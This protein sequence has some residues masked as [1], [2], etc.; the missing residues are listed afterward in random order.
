MIENFGLSQQALVNMVRRRMLG[1]KLPFLNPVLGLHYRGGRLIGV[2]NTINDITNQGKNDIFN[3]YFNNGTQTAN[4][5]W[6]IGLLNSS[7]FSAVVATDVMSSHGGWTEFTSY[8]ETNRVAWGSGTSTGQSVTN[9]TP[10]TFD[11][12]ASGTVKGVFI[13]TN[14]TKSGTTGVLWATALFGADVPV[15]NGDQLKITYTVSA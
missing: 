3:V 5:S 10:A 14:S 8:T 2:Y 6:F 4:N 1:N 11:I 7:G 13:V 9:A 15:T 12:N